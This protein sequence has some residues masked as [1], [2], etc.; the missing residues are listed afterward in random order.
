MFKSALFELPSNRC[1]IRGPKVPTKVLDK[2]QSC[3]LTSMASTS[4]IWTCTYPGL[5][6][7]LVSIFSFSLPQAMSE[8]IGIGSPCMH[9]PNPKWNKQKESY[10]I[11]ARGCSWYSLYSESPPSPFGVVSSLPTSPVPFMPSEYLLPAVPTFHH[12][13]WRDCLWLIQVHVFL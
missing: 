11:Q 10:N 7:S 8:I 3:S 12:L 4:Q 2:R 13:L 9:I 5:Q 1:K 6:L